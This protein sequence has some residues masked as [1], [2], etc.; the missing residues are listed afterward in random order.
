MTNVTLKLGTEM[1]APIDMGLNPDD[2]GY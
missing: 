2:K 1:P